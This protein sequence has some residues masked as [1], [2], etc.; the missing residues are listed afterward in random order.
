MLSSCAV[1]QHFQRVGA[2]MNSDVEQLFHELADRVAAERELY[3][4]THAVPAEI[5]TEVEVLLKFDAA[6]DRPLTEAIASSIE[7][8]LHSIDMDSSPRF[9]PYRLE[10]LLGRGGMASVYLAERADGEVSQRV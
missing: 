8:S 10:R 7:R 9:V 6:P 3:Y 2:Q 5:R 4:D 1:E